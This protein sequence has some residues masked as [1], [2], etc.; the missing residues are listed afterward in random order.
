ME[1]RN[2]RCSRIE[3]SRESY[4]EGRTYQINL[5]PEGAAQ[6]PARTAATNPSSMSRSKIAIFVAAGV[7][8]SGLAA[9][10]IHELGESSSGPESPGKP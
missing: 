8:G 5:D 4:R 3:T 9:W 7:A 6:K 10:G 2:S 1:R